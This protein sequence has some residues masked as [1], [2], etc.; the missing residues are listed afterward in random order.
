MLIFNFWHKK[1]KTRKIRGYKT[2]HTSTKRI[3]DKTNDNDNNKITIIILLIIISFK[4]SS[5]TSLIWNYSTE[6]GRSRKVQLVLFTDK[7]E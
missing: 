5:L 6:N 7:P 2:I 3:E 1:F 4:L